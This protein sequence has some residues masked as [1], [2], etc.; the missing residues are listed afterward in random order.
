MLDTNV[1]HVVALARKLLP[2]LIERGNKTGV[3]VNSSIAGSNPSP[4]F[5]TYAATK[6][7]IDYFVKGL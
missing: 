3:I 6:G 2:A 7:F 4:V 1:Y 5:A